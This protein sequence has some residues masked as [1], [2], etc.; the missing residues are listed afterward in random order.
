MEAV[1]KAVQFFPTFFPTFAF[2]LKVCF[3]LTNQQGNI[4]F[5]DI[6]DYDHMF[7]II[8]NCNLFNNFIQN[9]NFVTLFNCNYN[10]RNKDTEGVSYMQN[11]MFCCIYV[12]DIVNTDMPLCRCQTINTLN[13]QAILLMFIHFIC[14]HLA[15]NKW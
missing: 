2:K 1:V 10:H 3:H 13:I 11:A 8:C 15:M 7:I 12:I 5:T 9:V 14:I 6:I 4:S